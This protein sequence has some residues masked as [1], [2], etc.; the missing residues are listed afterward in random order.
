MKT[1]YFVRHG[2]SEANSSNVF[3]MPTAIIPL[4]QLGREQATATGK[5]MASQGITLQAIISSTLIRARSTAELAAQEVGFEPEK[6]ETDER[7]V[8]IECGRFNDM[9]FTPEN[10]RKRNEQY[11]IKGNEYGVEYIGDLV[12]RTESFKAELEKRPEDTILVVGHGFSGRALRRLFAGVEQT[13]PMPKMHNAELMQL[14]PYAEIT[15]PD[16]KRI[17]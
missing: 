6:V 7:L 10:E 9:E 2:E 16:R 12:R 11:M 17:L 4:T 15:D 14:Y 13:T 1:V 5:L 3:S 8:E